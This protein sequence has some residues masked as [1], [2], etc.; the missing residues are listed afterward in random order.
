MYDGVEKGYKVI[1]PRAL[2]RKWT[3]F[4]VICLGHGEEANRIFCT[5]FIGSQKTG[6]NGF[7]GLSPFMV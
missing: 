5:T 1:I 4:I 2:S 7:H 3:A 6:V